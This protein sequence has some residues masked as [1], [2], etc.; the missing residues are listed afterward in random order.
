MR[1][2]DATLEQ[3]ERLSAVLWK[4]DVVALNEYFR[5]ACAEDGNPGLIVD[6]DYALDSWE[7]LVVHQITW[8]CTQP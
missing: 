5:W 6:L 7:N 8:S 1:F 4:M 3:L 2:E